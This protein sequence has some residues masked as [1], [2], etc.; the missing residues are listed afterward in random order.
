MPDRIRQSVR[1][2]PRAALLAA[3]L[4]GPVLSVPSIEAGQSAVIEATAK[5]GGGIGFVLLV[6]LQRP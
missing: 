5:K 2:L 6:S 1:L 4:A 3:F